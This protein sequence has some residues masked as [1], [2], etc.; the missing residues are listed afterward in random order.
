MRF[1]MVNAVHGKPAAPFASLGMG[2]VASSLRAAY[3]DAITFKVVDNGL[4]EAIK[5]FQPDIVGISSMS[6]NYGVAQEHA[7]MAKQAGLP[8]LVGGVHVTELPQTLT[9]DMDVGIVCEGERTT[10]DV[11]A[12]FLSS[13]RLDKADLA[14]IAGIVYWDGDVLKT[15]EKR[16]LIR[17]L[18]S[19]PYPARDL[20]PVPPSANM[21][22][23]RGC[24]YRCAFCSTAH[25]TRNQVR[26]ASPEY[27][28]GEIESLS[29][30]HGVRYI[31]IYDDQFA[32]GNGR[33]AEIQ[34]LLG[35][36]NL[37]GKVHYSVNIRADFI[38][39]ELAEVFR[40]MGVKVVSFGAESGC[41]ETL[42]YLKSGGV[43]VEANA[44]AVATLR[45]HHITPYCAFQVGSPFEDYDG[46]ME[47]LRFIEDNR[48]THY[49]VFVTTPYPG[50]TLWDYALSRGLVSEG[51]DWSRLDME[52]AAS[53]LVL[54]EKLTLGE[55]RSLRGR[56]ERRQ[57]RYQRQV[58]WFVA[59]KVIS[60]ALVW[61]AI[62]GITGGKQ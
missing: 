23:S 52:M 45:R 40:E 15:T 3:G 31:T 19:I 27:V 17:P 5:S 61:K 7:R 14:S 37:L 43:T 6:K 26:Y 54:S 53:P 39:D 28:V 56:L 25:F 16:E 21:L 10:V 49:S 22:T 20:V 30:D 9:R 1:L 55:I 59:I 38:T 35:K 47:T 60:Q 41:A 44:R 34:Q 58:Q 48:L 4:H 62:R 51:M 32:M 46:V 36:K 24:P 57:K 29:R 12:A 11:M 33:V 2:Y 13:G 18:D 42:V 50:T 8:V